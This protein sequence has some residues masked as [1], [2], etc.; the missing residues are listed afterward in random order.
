MSTRTTAAVCGLVVA[1]V[2]AVGVGR[3]LAEG[4]H[5]LA[6]SDLARE[7]GEYAVAVA[8]AKR[9]AEAVVPFGPHSAQGYARLEEMAREAE[10][11]GDD[12]TA[13]AAWRAMRAA[14]ISTRGFGVGGGA[15]RHVAEDGLVRVA[16]QRPGARDP[17]EAVTEV[18]LRAAL[19]EENTPQ[20]WR[21]FMIA[22]VGAAFLAGAS[23]LLT[24]IQIDANRS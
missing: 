9:A 20:T 17:T 22:A 10:R 23:R 11:R 2:L 21:F 1:L 19:A 4:S 12:A 16:A 15:W 13:A 7:R 14:V 5:A 6:E 18:T 24:R 3:Q 8:A